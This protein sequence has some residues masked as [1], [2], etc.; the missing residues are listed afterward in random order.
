MD[1][2]EDRI[3]SLR[4]TLDIAE[5]LVS[6]V[7]SSQLPPN[8]P[9]LGLVD[10][11]PLGIREKIIDETTMLLFLL[12]RSP[13]VIGQAEQRVQRLCG[14]LR[15]LIS[16]PYYIAAAIRRPYLSISSIGAAHHM[17]DAL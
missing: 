5:V 16:D 1:L 7:A 9:R 11:Y 2:A 4:H 10:D 13:D 14:R 3:A 12:S 17:L 15:A 6:T 8:L